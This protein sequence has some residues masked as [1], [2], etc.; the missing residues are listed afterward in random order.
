MHKQNPKPRSPINDPVLRYAGDST[1]MLAIEQLAPIMVSIFALTFAVAMVINFLLSHFF[2][3]SP[4][5]LKTLSFAVPLIGLR[6]L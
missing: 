2:G 3:I 4:D 5:A 1:H 6:D